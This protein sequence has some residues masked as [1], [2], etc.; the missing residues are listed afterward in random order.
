MSLLP[1]LLSLFAAAPVE[2]RECEDYGEPGWSKIMGVATIDADRTTGSIEVAG[3]TQATIYHVEGFNRRWDFG[4]K[5]GGGYSYSFV[6]KP[7]GTGLYYDFT[8]E[9]NAVRASMV[10]DCRQRKS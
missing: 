10:M 6:I 7:D 4:P 5:K 9:D 8:Q 1:L 2:T 3:T